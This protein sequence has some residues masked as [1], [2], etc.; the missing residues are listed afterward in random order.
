M[1]LLTLLLKRFA[2]NEEW[3]E[4]YYTYGLYPYLSIGFRTIFGWIPFSVGD[5]LYTVAAVFLLF[6][7]WKYLHA[8]IKGYWR[9]SFNGA[10]VRRITRT[11]LVIYLAFNVLWGLNYDR[12]GLA[13]QFHLEVQPYNKED[14]LQLTAALQSRLCTYAEGL[15]TTGRRALDSN[16]VLFQKG[17]ASFA[18]IQPSYPFLKYTPSSIKASLI[19]PLGRYFGFTGYYNP[20]T[21]EAQLKTSVPA[22]VKP[23]VLCHEIAHQLGYAKENEA[24]FISFIVAGSSSDVHFRYAVYFDMYLYAL[25]ELVEEDFTLAWMVASTAHPQVQRDR[26]AYSEYLRGEKNSIEPFVSSFY[27]QYLKMNNQPKGRGSY[28]QVV[29]WLIALM[30]KDGAASI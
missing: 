22:F 13:R 27:D 6:K 7:T 23:F 30:K 3:V 26:R 9:A 24:N 19:T 28:N 20:F 8:A 4:Q 12:V 11:L 15:D 14:L 21:A 16:K 29:G 25:A 17:A 10:L 2:R 18:D 5:L 1:L